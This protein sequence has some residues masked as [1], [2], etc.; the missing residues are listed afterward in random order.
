M[1]S[2]SPVLSIY[3]SFFTPNR[4][5]YPRVNFCHNHSCM[6]C[7]CME[8]SFVRHEGGAVY[9]SSIDKRRLTGRL[10]AV[11]ALSTQCPH[12]YSIPHSLQWSC[13]HIVL[14]ECTS[15]MCSVF[16][17]VVY[18]SFQYIH[19]GWL[20]AMSPVQDITLC[21][22]SMSTS[23]HVQGQLHILAENKREICMQGAIDFPKMQVHTRGISTVKP[24][25]SQIKDTQYDKGSF[26]STKKLSYM[27]WSY[28]FWTSL[29]RTTSL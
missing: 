5:C 14:Y 21:R 18:S 20:Q 2:P 17:A 8:E 16:C 10:Q 23:C 29:E 4:C 15:C 13:L 11:R 25:T 9:R 12:Q 3:I 19:T 27:Q 24:P 26:W 22:T 7:V 6:L 28:I 1:L